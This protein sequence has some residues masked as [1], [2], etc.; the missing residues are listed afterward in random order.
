MILEHMR[1]SAAR[2]TFEPDRLREW[3]ESVCEGRVLNLFAGMTKLN[4]DEYRND[5][6]EDMPADSHQDA[7]E[8]IRSWPGAKF[9]TVILDPPYSLRKSMEKY[10]GAVAS[11][12]R[13]LK[14]NVPLILIPGGLVL[15]MGYQSV[16]MG[17]Q[18]GFKVERVLLISHGGAIHDTIAT[19]ERQFQPDL[20]RKEREVE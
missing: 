7:L 9:D 19:V 14:D 18:R 5:L 17:K 15:T 2:Y 8:F 20:F 6:R 4:C 13:Q 11:P 16:S 3:V 1:C 10:H 12:F